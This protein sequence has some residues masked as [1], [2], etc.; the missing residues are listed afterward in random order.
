[1]FVM[2]LV[3]FSA[4]LELNKFYFIFLK[5][6]MFK[7]KLFM[8]CYPFLSNGQVKFKIASCYCALNENRAAIAEVEPIDVLSLS[9]SLHVLVASLFHLI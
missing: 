9:L 7:V 8:H 5:L 1:M 6:F 3:S 2:N 4:Y